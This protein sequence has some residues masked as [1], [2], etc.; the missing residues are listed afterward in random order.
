M[1]LQTPI[2]PGA[3]IGLV[4]FNLC[5]VCYLTF[6]TALFSRLALRPWLSGPG[7]QARL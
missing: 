4:N 1:V 7:S 3:L 2:D 6:G 5:P